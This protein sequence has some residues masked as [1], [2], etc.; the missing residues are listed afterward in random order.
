MPKQLFQDKAGKWR[1]RVVGRNG[2]KMMT[3]E[4]YASM[5]NANRGYDDLKKEMI[6]SE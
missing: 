2:E 3:S 4:A 6:R 1:F 5:G